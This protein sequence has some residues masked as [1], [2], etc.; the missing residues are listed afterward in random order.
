MKFKPTKVAVYNGMGFG[1]Y[2]DFYIEVNYNNE[3][4]YNAKYRIY[5]S[6]KCCHVNND[7]EIDVDL[8]FKD[9]VTKLSIKYSIDDISIKNVIFY[10]EV[11]DGCFLYPETNIDNIVSFWNKDINNY[12]IISYDEYIIKQIIE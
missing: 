10:I 9:A 1:L 12:K 11:N 8:L 3:H 6:I 7:E 2:N 4:I 5:T